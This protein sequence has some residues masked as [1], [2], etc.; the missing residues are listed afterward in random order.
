MQH[1]S[2]P[3]PVRQVRYT[4]CD[5][6]P[7]LYN[8]D[9]LLTDLALIRREWGRKDE[10]LL[11]AFL[12]ELAGSEDALWDLMRRKMRRETTAPYFNSCAIESM[13]QAKYNLYRVRPLKAV[14]PYRVIYAL[15]T[16]WDDIYVL[17]IVRKLPADN[18]EYDS[19]KHYDYEPNHRISTRV[20]AEYDRLKLPRIA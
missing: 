15:D 14:T 2:N 12:D 1:F 5:I 8:G 11:E 20:V 4:L 6:V 10:R 3:V 18:R 16:E 9:D 13:H 19:E 7:D 17:A